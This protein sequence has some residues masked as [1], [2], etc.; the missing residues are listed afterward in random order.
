MMCSTW[1]ISVFGIVALMLAFGL[2]AGDAFAHSNGEHA[3]HT[4]TNVTHYSDAT[5]TVNVNSTSGDGGTGGAETRSDDLFNAA[6]PKLRATEKLDS[7][8]FTYEHG[9][10]QKKGTVTLTIPRPWTQAVRDNHDGNVEEG[11]IT[12]SGGNSYSVTSGGG[13]WQVKVNYTDDPPGYANAVI[14]YS[15]ITVPNR[16]GKY[17]FGVSS[18]TTGDGH[19]SSVDPHSTDHSVLDDDL[20]GDPD[21]SDPRAHSHSADAPNRGSITITVYDHT[22]G[23]DESHQHEN[24]PVKA[25]DGHSHP[26]DKTHTHNHADDKDD[27]TV[28]TGDDHST[29]SPGMDS[30]KHNATSGVA[31]Q[32]HAH[33]GTVDEQG[34]EHDDNGDVRACCRTGITSMVPMAVP[35]IH[36]EP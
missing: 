4:R 3:G 20:D 8:V 18:T 6:T 28:N 17:E 15:K 7:L 36:P 14:T 2:V 27:K 32:D 29:H 30:H 34:H 24:G 23:P 22:H 33:T 13:G 21:A 9:S 25:I 26:S 5:I 10:H 31:Q 12:V 1:K 19:V 11:E 35:L 16:A